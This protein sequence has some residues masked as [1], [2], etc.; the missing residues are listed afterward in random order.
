V[1]TASNRFL[2]DAD[3]LCWKLR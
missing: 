1:A 3:Q 2:G